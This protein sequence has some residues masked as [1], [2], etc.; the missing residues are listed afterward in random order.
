[1]IGFLQIPKILLSTISW[2]IKGSIFAFRRKPL[3]L[4][5]KAESEFKWSFEEIEYLKGDK[6]KFQWEDKIMLP[7][8]KKLVLYKSWYKWKDVIIFLNISFSLVIILTILLITLN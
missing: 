3:D 2:W 6:A 4:I 1:M 7:N 8:L 5:N